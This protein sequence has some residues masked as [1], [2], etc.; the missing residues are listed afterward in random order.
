MKQTKK[1]RK[2]RN[3][4]KA[5]DNEATKVRK[6]SKNGIKSR[7]NKTEGKQRKTVKK[8]TQRGG[9]TSARGDIKE[10][11]AGNANV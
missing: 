2:N 5:G 3:R 1:E 9:R 7:E 10:S 8:E 11:H 4:T 6:A